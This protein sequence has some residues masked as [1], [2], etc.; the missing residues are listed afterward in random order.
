MNDSFTAAG[1]GWQ[2]TPM[3]WLVR[4]WTATIQSFGLAQARQI[5]AAPVEQAALDAAAEMIAIL[6][7]PPSSC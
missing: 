4:L 3:P 5:T 2:W 7:T 6:D 1:S